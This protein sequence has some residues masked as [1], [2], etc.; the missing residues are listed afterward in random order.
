[1]HESDEPTTTVTLRA[2]KGEPLADGEL[3]STVMAMALA[4]A[5]RQGVRVIQVDATES[6]ITTTLVGSRIVGIGFAAELR[7]LTERWHSA[8][9]GGATLW[10][11]VRHNDRDT[12]KPEADWEV[13]TDFESNDVDD[14]D[15]G[16]WWK[17]A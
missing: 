9:H 1:M 12:E 15:D 10:G 11:E 7:R 14:G 13:E 3:R 2:L 4:V 5:E 17:R 8:K 16:D 6:S